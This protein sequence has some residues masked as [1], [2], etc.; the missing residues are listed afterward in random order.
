MVNLGYVAA[1]RAG[2]TA[3]RVAAGVTTAAET[4]PGDRV[5]GAARRC[6]PSPL[7]LNAARVALAIQLQPARMF[8]MLDFCWPSSTWSGRSPRAA[9]ARGSA[10]RDRRRGGADGCWRS[11]AAPTS[12]ASS[13][14]NGP[15]FEPAVPRRL[16]PGRGVGADRRRKT[17][18]GSPIRC[19]PR[20]YGTSLR[21]AAARDVFVEGTKDAAIGMYD[22]SDRVP[23]QGSAAASRGLPGNV[24]RQLRDVGPDYRL[25]LPDRDEH[26]HADAARLSNRAHPR[27][28]A[29]LT[30]P[31]HR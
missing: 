7:P 15:L 30:I 11:C 29:A 4:R 27:L 22:R 24:S 14:P 28:S 25:D 3:G 18:A 5:P 9:A 23:D 6:S 16:G 21:M 13:S 19:T 26:G 2:S 20:C 10:P 17:A 12:C 8:W 1:H 31:I